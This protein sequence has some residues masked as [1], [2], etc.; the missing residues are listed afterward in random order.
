MQKAIE[1]VRKWPT[2]D[3]QIF[4]HNDADGICSGAILTR[5]FEREG[6]KI[7]RFSLEKPYPAVL[8]KIFDQESGLIVFADFGGR[9]APMLSSLN[10]GRNLTLILDHH[11]AEKSADPGDR[12][13]NPTLYGKGRSGY[14][15]VHYLLSVCKHHESLEP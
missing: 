10:R 7:H 3:V 2:K 11:V 1:A 14:F 13:L 15:R 4:H 6:A 12:N 5:A 8:Q 9:I